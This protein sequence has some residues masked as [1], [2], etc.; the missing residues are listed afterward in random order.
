MMSD[1]I[2]PRIRWVFWCGGTRPDV[3]FPVGKP[4]DRQ[5]VSGKLRR[6][7]GVSP[8]F[9]ASKTRGQTRGSTRRKRRALGHPGQSPRVGAGFI[10]KPMAKNSFGAA[11]K[12][13][14]GTADYHYFR[15]AELVRQ[16]VGNVGHLPFSI[17]ILLENLLRNEDGK[18][19]TP[20]DVAAV[21]GGAGAGVKEIS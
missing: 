13:R 1:I 17:R 19:V 10:I 9:A 21:A 5:P 18:R 11:A 7:L 12:L 3:A 4:W 16:G 2:R 14:V 8:G 20:Q 6:K 15:L